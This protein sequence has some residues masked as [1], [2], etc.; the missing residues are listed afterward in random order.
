M[1]NDRN[2]KKLLEIQQ[3]DSSSTSLD[4]TQNPNDK[5][6]TTNTTTSASTTTPTPTSQPTSTMLIID[7]INTVANQVI[8]SPTNSSSSNYSSD[9]VYHS[10]PSE[11]LLISSN[12]LSTSN[13][14]PNPNPVKPVLN[15]DDR[16]IIDIC[17]S[18]LEQTLETTSNNSAL[19]A[20]INNQLINNKSNLDN[21]FKIDSDEFT[22]LGIRKCV[23]F[24]MNLPGNSDLCTDDRAKL[25]KY[26]VYEIALLRLAYRFNKSTDCIYLTNG[27]IVNEATLSKPEYFGASYGRLFFKYCRSFSKF[28]LSPLSFSLLCALKFFA[29][30]R[31]LL[32]ER[33]KVL[34]IQTKYIQLFEYALEQQQ[35]PKNTPPTLNLAHALLSLIQLRAIDVLTAEKML[36]IVSL[37]EKTGVEGYIT[38]VLHREYLNVTSEVQVE[39]AD[40]KINTQIPTPIK[41]N[42]EIY[43]PVK[44]NKLIQPTTPTTPSQPQIQ[45]I[46]PQI[47][48]LQPFI[49]SQGVNQGVNQIGSPGQAGKQVIYMSSQSP[50]KAN[51]LIK[52]NNGMPMVSQSQMIDAGLI[53]T[54]NQSSQPQILN[55]VLV[56]DGVNGSYL[57]LVPQQSNP[58]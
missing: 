49:P 3:K 1:R 21:L 15:D 20:Q 46:K 48:K 7:S 50:V 38:E 40:L 10:N 9:R 53:Q 39:P 12:H 11:N 28:S 24:C 56:T 30:D 16:E 33:N 4:T 23:K 58:N 52:L 17:K 32:I 55:L 41:L 14:N 42:N 19:L 51:K 5:S 13:D 36:N 6:I 18:L 27:S 54:D 47:I 35:N 29:N 31:P 37:N 45:S 34:Q 44:I 43:S 25:L 2:K 22:Q 26:G 8:S 57:S